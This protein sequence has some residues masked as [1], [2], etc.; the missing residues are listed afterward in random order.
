MWIDVCGVD[1]LEPERGVA[2]LLD[3]EQVAVFRLF[4]GTLAAVQNLDPVAG[5]CV[6]SRG[7]VGSR[8]ERP[9][10]ASPIYKQ[11]YDLH[12]GECLDAMGAE[13][14]GAPPR[15]ACRSVRIS[16][17][18][19]EIGHETPVSVVTEAATAGAA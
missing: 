3:G 4:D 9:T 7:I 15:L 11:V 13:V 6:M 12:T 1:D 19:V 16:G 10:I 17:D 2:A 18:R 5:A 8:G 14:D